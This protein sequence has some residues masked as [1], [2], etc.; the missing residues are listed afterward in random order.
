MEVITNK[1]NIEIGWNLYRIL[2]MLSLLLFIYK[3]IFLMF[4]K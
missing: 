3:I 1:I 4:K 2:V